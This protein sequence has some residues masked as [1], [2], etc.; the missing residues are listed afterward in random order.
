M[1]TTQTST[2]LLKDCSM[3]YQ[4]DRDT[5]SIYL[6]NFLNTGN[7]GNGD[8]TLFLKQSIEILKGRYRKI[9]ENDLIIFAD[10]NTEGL[11][12]SLKAGGKIK[13]IL[14]RVEWL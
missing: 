12:V 5:H 2:L 14:T 13:Q 7:E 1:G 3:D 6:Y 4:Y 10:C 8:F 9:S 11:A